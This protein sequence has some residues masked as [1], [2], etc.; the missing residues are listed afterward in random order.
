M[1]LL[2]YVLMIKKVWDLAIID[3]DGLADSLSGTST[4]IKAVVRIFLPHDGIT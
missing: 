2:I 4:G 1:K 3:E